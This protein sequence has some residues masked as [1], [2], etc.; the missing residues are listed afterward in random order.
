MVSSDDGDIIWKQMLAYMQSG[1]M[2]AKAANGNIYLADSKYLWVLDQKDGH[3]VWRQLLPGTGSW[4]TDVSVDVI[5]INEI[6]TRIRAYKASTGELLWQNPACRGYLHAKVIANNVY[7]PCY[8]VDAYNI[9]S[10]EK[11]WDDGLES[12]IGNVGYKNNNIYYFIDSVKAYDLERKV[13]LWDTPV[14]AIK[15]LVRLGVYGNNIFVYDAASICMIDASEGFLLWCN[16]N[17]PSPQSPTI[18]GNVVYVFSGSHKSVLALD[19]LTGNEIGR[20]TLPKISFFVVYRQLM[21]SLD[22]CLYIG[23]EKTVHTF[24][25][26]PDTSTK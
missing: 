14:A 12:R 13:L 8:G 23:N 19:L 4:V 17:I 25:N 7:I 26:S 15:G 10:G 3:V 20:L 9:V 1:A 18:V 22:S 16:R 2:P 21:V 6:G 24:C 5:L 11:I